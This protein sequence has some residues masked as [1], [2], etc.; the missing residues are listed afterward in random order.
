M[1][2]HN[3]VTAPGKRV[4]LRT[5]PDVTPLNRPK[6]NTI[7]DERKGKA[8]EQEQAQRAQ[9]IAALTQGGVSEREYLT[10]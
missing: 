1:I 2:A 3:C 8:D 9:I 4:R 5:A 6:S 7:L 10:L